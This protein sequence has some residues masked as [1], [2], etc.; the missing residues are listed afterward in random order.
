M[1]GTAVL[2]G[3]SVGVVYLAVFATW[4]TPPAVVSA[5][6]L[7]ILGSGFVG[8]L[9]DLFGLSQRYKAVLPFLA[10]LPLGITVFTSLSTELL[11][12]DIG[13]LMILLVPLGVTSAANAANMLE[14]YNGL[15]AGLG[16]IMSTALIVL[17]FLLGAD[18]GLFLL[19]PLLAALLAFLWYNRYPARVFPGDS[20]TLTVGAA[21]ACAAIVSQPSFKLYGLVLFVPMIV[22]FALKARGRFRAENYGYVA[23]DGRLSYH[24]RV[25]S[26]THLL[27]RRGHLKEWQVVAI[28]WGVEAGL[29]AALLVAV[30]LTVVR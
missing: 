18:A 16:V 2:L 22:E 21:I 17:A 15:G 20:M 19:V 30:A 1:G 23:P 9:D 7:A 8:I 13:L 25:E 6:M 14:G 5:A 3:F 26:L 28:L 12:F 4:V 24:G 11:G 27:I 29:A 10:S